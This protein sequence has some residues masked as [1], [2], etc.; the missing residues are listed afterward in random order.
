MSRVTQGAND[1]PTINN[2][3]ATE[4]H[5]TRNGDLLP[6][7]VSAGSARK[8]WRRCSQGH[9]WEASVSSRNRGAGCPF[10]AGHRAAAGENDLATLNPELAAEWHPTKNGSLSPTQVT[11]NS[12]KKVW[13][14]GG[15]GHEWEA[16]VASRSRGSDCPYCRG[17]KVLTGFNDLAAVNAK[18]AAEWHPTRNGDLLPTQITAGSNE[19]VWWLGGCG[20][21]WEAT[22]VSRSNGH[23]CPYCANIRVLDGFNDLATRRPDCLSWWDYSKNDGQN[24][25]PT[26]VMPGSKIKAWWHCGS[27][28]SWTQA[29]NSFLKGRPSCPVCSGKVCQQGANDLATV[30]PRLAA[31]WHPTKNGDLLPT[32]VTAGSNKRVWWLGGCGHEWEA[33]VV[34]RAAG[35]NC[36]YCANKLVLAGFNDLAT[37]HPDIASEWNF[38]RNGALFPTDFTYGSERRVWWVCS[39]CGNE[40]QATIN[41]RTN[42]YFGTGC[43]KCSGEH[44]TSF[45]EQATLYYVQ[46]HIDSEAKSRFKVEMGGKTE[47]LDVWIPSL[48]CGI[49]YDGEFYHARRREKDAQKDLSAHSASIRLIRLIEC[50]RNAIENDRIYIDVHHNR[51]KNIEHAIRHAVS[52]LAGD[53]ITIDMTIDT[54]AI[55]SNYKLQTE[56]KSIKALFPELA[57]QWD[58][59]RNGSLLPENI[60]YGSSREVWWICPTCGKSFLKSVNVRTASRTRG[61]QHCPYCPTKRGQASRR[62]V[63][64]IET[65]KVYASLS[66]AAIDASRS[67]SAI[68]RAC[69]TGSVCAGFHWRYAGKR[70]E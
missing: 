66:D 67:T 55:M 46:Q 39:V 42:G 69:A 31:E 51:K 28:H 1:L 59:D 34:S 27:G 15:C 45:P 6:S 38:R 18:L 40:W 44:G 9:E 53:P 32:Q 70:S 48:R 17:S 61:L 23:G 35:N 4:W 47:E 25:F 50:D 26:Q 62:S 2:Q 49:E 33:T 14:L 56:E 54:P 24:I 36:P 41:N 43:P 64:C 58:Y 8:V 68:S 60:S 20:H 63:V 7:R 11:A 12:N 10:C 29:I 13:W 22:V 37:T 19:K 52:M 21:E 65:G 16:T 5:P 57:K 3:L 30:N